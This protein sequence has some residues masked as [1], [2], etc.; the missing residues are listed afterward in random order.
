MRVIINGFRLCF[1]DMMEYFTQTHRKN[2]KCDSFNMYIRE[3]GRLVFQGK[4]IREEWDWV[5]TINSDDVHF[6]ALGMGKV[7]ARF[8]MGD[9][10][11]WRRNNKL[12]R[13]LYG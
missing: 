10:V 8:T 11:K 1:E 4:L 5:G 13:I 2:I 9:Y 12:R 6:E 3:K 7:K